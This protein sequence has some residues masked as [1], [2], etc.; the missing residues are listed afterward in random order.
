MILR[1]SRL[2][3]AQNIVKS[4]KG[5]ALVLAVIALGLFILAVWL[6]DGWRR[7]AVRAT[8]WCLIGIGVIVVL[9]RR[10]IG[11]VLIDSLSP[12]S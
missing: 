8:G 12:H 6:A 5:S 7:V 11:D 4:I 3:T 1:S 2:K 10:I 9:T